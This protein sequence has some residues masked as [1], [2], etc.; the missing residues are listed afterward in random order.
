[1]P[2]ILEIRDRKTL[3]HGFYPF[4]RNRAREFNLFVVA[5]FDSWGEIYCRLEDEKRRTVATLDWEYYRPSWFRIDGETITI[6][7]RLNDRLP[8]VVKLCDDW[9]RD[10]GREIVIEVHP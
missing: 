5:H 7:M 10:G 3:K 4:L 1:M 9:E 6:K 8:D 2:K